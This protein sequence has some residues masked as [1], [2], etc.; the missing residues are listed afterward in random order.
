ME[1]SAPSGT[2]EETAHS[3]GAI[4]VGALST[5]ETFGLTNRKKMMA[6]NLDR[7]APY[8]VAALDER[9]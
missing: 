9:P 5:L 4:N 8:Q 2:K 7:L 1:G 6:I 3:L